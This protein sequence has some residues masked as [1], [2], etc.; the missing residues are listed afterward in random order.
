MIGF[1]SNAES[2]RFPGQLSIELD[3]MKVGLVGADTTF[4]ECVRAHISYQCI[5]HFIFCASQAD[6]DP[7][8]DNPFVEYES[9]WCVG[10]NQEGIE[11]FSKILTGLVSAQVKMLNFKWPGDLAISDLS[12]LSLDVRHGPIKYLDRNLSISN[13]SASDFE[14]LIKSYLDAAFTKPKKY[15]HERE[16]RF[17]ITPKTRN[18]IIPVEKTDLFLEPNIFKK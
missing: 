7:L 18:H 4:F 9:C 15:Q 17:S 8:D 6:D 16:Y 3:E 5:N 12:E 1:G 11:R 13:G 10:K 2:I 14:K